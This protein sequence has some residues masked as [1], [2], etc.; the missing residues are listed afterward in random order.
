[1]AEHSCETC[2]FRARYDNNP[3]SF[4]GRL[5][6]WHTKWCPGWKGY[7]ASLPDEE[8]K[9]LAEKYDM[10]KYKVK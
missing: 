9:G 5:W 7:M 10:K 2:G 1:M 8:R 6:K 3:K 4:W